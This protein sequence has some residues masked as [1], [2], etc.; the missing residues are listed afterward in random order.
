MEESEDLRGLEPTFEGLK[1][2]LL[3]A[4]DA[5]SVSL[6]LTSSARVTVLDVG[7]KLSRKKERRPTNICTSLSVSSWGRTF[8][9]LHEKPSS[10]MSRST[11]TIH[12]VPRVPFILQARLQR[13][14]N[15]FRRDSHA[16]EGRQ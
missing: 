6:P 16:A 14:F 8:R 7:K 11:I 1:D 12:A 4:V 10:R 2:Q 3:V 5:L 13:L 15:A 9:S